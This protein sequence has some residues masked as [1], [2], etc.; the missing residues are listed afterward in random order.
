M[1]D[2]TLIVN[3]INERFDDVNA[4]IDDLKRDVLATGQMHA[5]D[6]AEQFSKVESDMNDLKKFKWMLMGAVSAASSGSVVAIQKVLEH[7]K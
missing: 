1:I 6:D 3:L 2:E 7:F 4:R 5:K